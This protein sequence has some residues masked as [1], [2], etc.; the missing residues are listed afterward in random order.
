MTL[1]FAVN[2][3]LRTGVFKSHIK[4]LNPDA[5]CRYKTRSEKLRDMIYD[6]QDF[7]G[8]GQDFWLNWALRQ[9]DNLKNRPGKYFTMHFRGHL[10]YYCFC[11]ITVITLAVLLLL[12]VLSFDEK[13]FAFTPLSDLKLKLSDFFTNAIKVFLNQG[14]SEDFNKGFIFWKLSANREW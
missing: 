14:L 7:S 12:F 4:S 9:G 6:Y 11:E 1:Q 10:Q 3:Q 2:K 13:A 5:C 8:E